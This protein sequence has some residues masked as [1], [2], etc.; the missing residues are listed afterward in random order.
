MWSEAAILESDIEAWWLHEW[1]VELTM[2]AAE[3]PDT[4]L[5]R[6]AGR[7]SKAKPNKEDGAW[8]VEA[9][10]DMC[11]SYATYRVAEKGNGFDTWALPDGEPAIEVQFTFEL[12]DGITV[13]GAIDRIMCKDGQLRVRDLKTTQREPNDSAQLGIYKLAIERMFDETPCWGDYYLARDA[14]ASDPVDLTHYT[15]ELFAAEYGAVAK[16]MSM[17][18]YPANP[19]DACGYCDVKDACAIKG[20]K[21]ADD[22]RFVMPS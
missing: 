13:R 22:W 17:G 16:M 11:K 12:V 14:N 2:A 5:Y 1:D 8:W 19:G 4:T 10:V 15:Q 3:E 20:G 18:L 6:A 7:R 21:L 9:G